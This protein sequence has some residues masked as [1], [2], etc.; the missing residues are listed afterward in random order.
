VRI[1]NCAAAVTAAEQA[2][3]EEAQF[4]ART[5]KTSLVHHLRTRRQPMQLAPSHLPTLS[6]P[7]AFLPLSDECL[8]LLLRQLLWLR[9]LLPI[10]RSPFRGT[11]CLLLLTA[12]LVPAPTTMLMASKKRARMR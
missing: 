3:Q 2:R 7:R 12:P 1:Y 9:L 8:L 5:A 11:V 4:M 6:C 10:P